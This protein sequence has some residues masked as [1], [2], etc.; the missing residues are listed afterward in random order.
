MPIDWDTAA[1][2]RHFLEAKDCTEKAGNYIGHSRWNTIRDIQHTQ[3][4]LKCAQEALMDVNEALE[5]IRL[6]IE[7]EKDWED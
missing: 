7:A 6:E 1:V 4:W 5:N 2:R 3:T